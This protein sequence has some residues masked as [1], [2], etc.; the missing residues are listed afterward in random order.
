MRASRRNVSSSTGN[1][2]QYWLCS[3]SSKELDITTVIVSLQQATNKDIA[4][5]I[6]FTFIYYSYSAIR[7]P[8]SQGVSIMFSLLPRVVAAKA[9]R[10]LESSAIYRYSSRPNVREFYSSKKIVYKA[11][12]LPPTRHWGRRM[13]GSGERSKPNV[14]P[15]DKNKKIVNRAP[16]V[17]F[18][19]NNNN[20]IVYKAPSLPTRQCK[21]LGGPAP[22]S[23]AS[24]T[25]ANNAFQVAA[26][27][28]RAYWQWGK[29]PKSPTVVPGLELYAVSLDASKPMPF[30]TSKKYLPVQA[31]RSFSSCPALQS[32][33]YS[34]TYQA[35]VM[36]ERSRNEKLKEFKAKV[37]F[38]GIPPVGPDKSLMA[39][40][41]N[42]SEDQRVDFE[43][44]EYFLFR[45]YLAD[46]KTSGSEQS[47]AGALATTLAE[48]IIDSIRLY[49]KPL[50]DILAYDGNRPQYTHSDSTKKPD[51]FIFCPPDEFSLDPKCRAAIVLV[52]EAKSIDTGTGDLSKEA[53]SQLENAL[54]K[55]PLHVSEDSV[56]PAFIVVGSFLQIGYLV[57]ESTGVKFYPCED[58]IDVSNKSNAGKGAHALL[59][60][61]LGIKHLYYKQ[62]IR[63]QVS[64]AIC[65]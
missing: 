2:S 14:G 18:H 5:S 9:V 6:D 35:I 10:G 21:A 58:P 27:E 23:E 31:R 47:G 22:S 46:F 29:S 42:L 12:N 55:W 19:N 36:H 43:F 60:L 17:Q 49:D 41:G 50:G 24:V 61:E 40:W 33:E 51:I 48:A 26:A 16:R 15:F 4:A 39:E 30:I 44:F 34:D 63:N 62:C 45:R 11:P 52:G 32:A 28:A 56:I 1:S 13:E 65:A 20:N 7:V 3:H 25:N 53:T 64:D 38:V 57:K 8:T 54:A 37:K 59:R